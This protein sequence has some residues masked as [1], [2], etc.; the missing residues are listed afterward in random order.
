MERRTNDS[1]DNPIVR[2]FVKMA[3]WLTF[4]HVMCNLMVYVLQSA[5]NLAGRHFRDGSRESNMYLNGAFNGKKI[6][7]WGEYGIAISRPLINHIVWRSNI[8]KCGI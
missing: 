4:C 3:Q 2:L 8:A 7:N 5:I 1:P 6:A